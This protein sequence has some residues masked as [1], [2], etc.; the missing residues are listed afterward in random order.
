MQL[1]IAQDRAIREVDKWFKNESEKKQVFTLFGHA[2]TGKTTLAKHFAEN[3]NGVVKYATFT[4]KAAHVMRKK[5]CAGASTIHQLIYTP[6]SHS[7]NKLRDLEEELNKLKAEPEPNFEAIHFIEEAINIEKENVGR[8]SF[9]LNSESEL[10]Y[11]DLLIIDEISMVNT[12]Q[13]E[14][15]LSFGTPILCLGDPEQLPPVYGTGYFTERKPEILLTEIHRQALDNP[16]IAMSKIVREGG[17]LPLGNYGDSKVIAQT[18]PSEEILRHDIILTGLRRTKK[19]CDDKVRGLRGFD[20]QF[21]KMGDSI[22]CIKNNHLLGLLNG[23]IWECVADAY[24]MGDSL[25]S[26]QV[27]DPE[28]GQEL[29]LTAHKK[30][31]LGQSLE[32]FEHEQDIEEFEYAYAI[33]VHKSQG[34]QWNNI[35]LFDQKDSFPYWS[36]RDRRRWLYTGITRAAEKI[37]VMRL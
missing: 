34:S 15:L 25:L 3:I 33:T 6:K 23:Q 1:S 26:L 22:M 24:D 8:L 18:L 11:A 10:R 29:I 32:R 2:G 17:V 13:A 30:P 37:T 21:P 14:D 12:Q 27:R 5:G 4:G 36:D 9:A 35:L 20:H 19:A 16:I 7:K 28:T 31:F